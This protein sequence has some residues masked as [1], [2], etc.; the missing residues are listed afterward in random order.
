M[1]FLLLKKAAV[2]T[3]TY[4]VALLLMY[5]VYI[6]MKLKTCVRLSIK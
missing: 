5:V 6:S 2:F 3:V 4:S 1:E